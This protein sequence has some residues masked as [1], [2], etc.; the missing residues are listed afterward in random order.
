ME[1]REID[2]HH[3]EQINEII[4]VVP[5]WIIRWG[6]T[7]FLIVLIAIFFLSTVIE[8]PQEIKLPVKVIYKDPLI[9][10]L[11]EVNGK[12][13]TIFIKD[14][15]KVHA[16]QA[17]ATIQDDEHPAKMPTILKAEVTGRIYFDENTQTG[18]LVATTQQIFFFAR[19]KPEF[20][21]E[22]EIPQDK[23]GMI[24]SGQ[25]GTIKLNSYN[26]ETYGSL[27]GR[28]VYISD[29]AYQGKT[30]NSLMS[31]SDNFK[32]LTTRNI[33]L[34]YGMIG[35]ANIVVRNESLFKMMFSK[36]TRF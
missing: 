15:Q 6:I 30:F 2:N 7:F 12:I 23:I 32:T 4:G 1:E 29:I 3:S 27:H 25:S 11:S 36:V 21:C 8:Y 5:P 14:G 19:T 13:R 22:L 18:K 26:S 17:L 33:D 31:I 9:P 34:K 24:K 28:I 16:G 20:I 10:I 35:T